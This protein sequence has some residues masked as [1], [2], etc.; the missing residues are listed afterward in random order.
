ML[1]ILYH[2]EDYLVVD[3]PAG[4]LVH[5]TRLA[6][7]DAPCALQLVRDMVGQHVYPAHRLDRPTSG[8]LLFAMHSA[9][10]SYLREQFDAHAVRKLYWAVVRGYTATH[11]RIEH[12]LRHP[13]GYYSSPAD[14]QAAEARPALTSYT[15]LSQTELAIPCGPHPTSRYSLVALE[16]HTGRT[17]QLRRH[18]HHIAHPIIGDTRYGH[19][20]HNRLFRD[21][22]GCERLLLAAVSLQFTHG[23]TGQPVHITAPLAPDFASVIQAVGLYE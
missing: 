16:P 8:I 5:R 21:H 22:F 23:R 14:Y 15:Q 10:A 4:M 1:P 7:D 11:G 9:A 6:A 20:D 12:P 17:H 19:G 18:M 2:D 13:K 3:K